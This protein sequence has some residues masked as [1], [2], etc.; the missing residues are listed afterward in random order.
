MDLAKN[1][2]TVILKVCKVATDY[3][4]TKERWYVAMLCMLLSFVVIVDINDYEFCSLSFY[5]A[6]RDH[7]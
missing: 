6:G 1:S 3:E 7:T 4:N 2:T 5:K